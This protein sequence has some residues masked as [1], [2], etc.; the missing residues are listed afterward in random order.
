MK[1]HQRCFSGVIADSEGKQT[2]SDIIVSDFIQSMT[3]P[4]FDKQVFFMAL[5]NIT[6]K[7]FYKNKRKW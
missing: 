2:L 3:P 4:N 1:K 5:I 6:N 7:L